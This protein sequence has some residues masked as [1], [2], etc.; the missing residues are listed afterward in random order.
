MK[1][2]FVCTLLAL[3]VVG[4][5]IANQSTFEETNQCSEDIDCQGDFICKNGLCDLPE[6]QQSLVAKPTVTTQIAPPALPG[7]AYEPLPVS[8]E[9]AGPFTT[10][11]QGT[12]TA[13]NYQTRAGV[14]NV[15]EAIVEEAE[16]TGYVAIEKAYTFGPSRYVVV[17][18][19][20]EGGNACPASTY[21]FSLDAKAER[22][23]GKREVDGCSELVEVV[24]EG[25]RLMVKKEGGGTVVFNGVVE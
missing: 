22:V 9:R 20:G 17:V 16:Y 10:Q 4:Y 8:A 15:M 12:G 2:L 6:P 5:A 3:A 14:V 21:V 18:S 13:L 24:V 25:N 19:T 1:R 23:D 7:V 11:T